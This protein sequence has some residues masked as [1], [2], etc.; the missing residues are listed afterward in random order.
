M[1]AGKVGRARIVKGLEC[2][3]RSLN[4]T[5]LA[6]QNHEGIAKQGYDMVTSFYSKHKNGILMYVFYDLFSFSISVLFISV[7]LDLPHFFN[8]FQCMNTISFTV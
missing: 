7:H 3:V 6:V 2:Q 5:C 1:R 8:N 4:F